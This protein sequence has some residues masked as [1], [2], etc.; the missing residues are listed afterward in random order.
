M[1]RETFLF[2]FLFLGFAVGFVIVVSGLLC[3]FGAIFYY[4]IWFF[5]LSVSP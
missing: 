4:V 5:I 2:L 3:A 1:K